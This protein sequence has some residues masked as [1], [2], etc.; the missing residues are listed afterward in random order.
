[1]RR[2]FTII[3]IAL[4]L[5]ALWS[6]DIFGTEHTHEFGE[7]TVI[8][9]AT[10]T[11]DGSR[12]RSCSCGESEKETLLKTGHT[13]ETVTGK[14][15]TCTEAGFTEGKK[16]TVCGEMTV[17]QEIVA[18]LGHDFKY[19]TENDNDGNAINFL[20]CQ[21]KDCKEQNENVAGLYDSESNLI[22]F[23]DELKIG[24]EF[25]GLYGLGDALQKNKSFATVTTIIID[26]SVT[27]I[28]LQSF[29]ECT[30]ITTI[31]ISSNVTKIN[32]HL[33]EKPIYLKNI[34]VDENNEHYK[35]IDG[36]LYTKDGKMLI[37]YAV[38]KEDKEFT[39]PDGVER[40]GV[41]AFAYCNSLENI[42]IPNSVT[43]IDNGL[44]YSCSSLKNIYFTGS[45]DEWEAIKYKSNWLPNNALIHYDGKKMFMAYGFAGNFGSSGAAGM[46]QILKIGDNQ[47]Y[48]DYV[49]YDTVSVYDSYEFE[50]G[51][52]IYS[53]INVHKETEKLDALD[54]IKACGKFYILEGTDI[55]G[56]LQTRV[57]CYFDGTFYL[58]TVSSIDEK[59][60]IPIINRINYSIFDWE[61]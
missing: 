6:C 53:Y 17:K 30:N 24:N 34:I 27:T 36:N 16:C 41:L 61:E 26:D 46:C 22:A 21:R 52:Y 38:G 54:K 49:M 42:V 39:V 37:Q 5:L 20:L 29:E 25:D 59:T 57:C 31:V 50:Y 18:A 14:K 13:E 9:E 47:L 45:A 8:K 56:I 51:E 33:L 48:I 58:L 28:G 23:W 15:A 10:C 44:F 12:T 11:E 2:I 4:S 55:K 35:S 32:N 7:W 43:Q 3:L 19:C 60:G 1:M 40:I